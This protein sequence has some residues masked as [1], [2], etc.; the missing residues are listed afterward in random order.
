MSS[1][2]SYVHGASEKQLIGQTIG[3]FFDEACASHAEREAL[4]VR[5]QDVRLTYAQLKLKVDAL[6]CGLMRLG[7]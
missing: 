1:T 5:H 4:I 6:A 2:A 7:L 3:R